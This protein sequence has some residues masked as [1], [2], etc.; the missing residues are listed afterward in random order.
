MIE[1]CDLCSKEHETGGDYSFGGIAWKI[2]PEVPENTQIPLRR[3]PI[4]VYGP[5]GEEFHSY[6]VELCGR[7]EEHSLETARAEDTVRL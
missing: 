1:R 4:V 7:G 5:N 3:I 2:C 6:R